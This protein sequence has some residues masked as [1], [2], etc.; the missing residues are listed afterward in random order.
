M[1][2]LSLRIKTKHGNFALFWFSDL[3]CIIV[4]SSPVVVKELRH[5]LPN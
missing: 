3:H 4:P 1:L 5:P 2:D